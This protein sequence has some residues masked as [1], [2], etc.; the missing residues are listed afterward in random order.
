[1]VDGIHVG[2]MAKA[3]WSELL[4]CFYNGKQFLF[5]SRIVGLRFTQLKEKYMTA[6]YPNPQYEH[7]TAPAAM[8]PSIL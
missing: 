4:N 3:V 6:Q 1:M 5:M 2:K 8:Y 7:K